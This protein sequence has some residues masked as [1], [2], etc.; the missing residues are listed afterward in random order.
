MTFGTARPKL[1]SELLCRNVISPENFI[2]LRSKKVA[3]NILFGLA[4][5]A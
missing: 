5:V 3:E 1:N 2:Q 4:T